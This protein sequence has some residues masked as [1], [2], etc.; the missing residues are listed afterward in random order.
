MPTF[1]RGWGA[2]EFDRS[3]PDLT[4][5]ALQAYALWQPFMRGR[6]ALW[7]GH[8]QRKA[9]NYLRR[10]QRGDGSWVPL[11]FGN[12]HIPGDVNPTYATARVVSCLAQCDSQGDGI[13]RGRSWLIAAQR[14]DGSWGGG[15][16]SP[17]SIEETG[18]AL[19]ALSHGTVDLSIL[20]RGQ[21]ALQRLTQNGQQF[22]PAPI[23]FYFAKLWYFERLYP[24]IFATAGMSR[25]VTRSAAVGLSDRDLVSAEAS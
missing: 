22:Q 24:L 13:R 5:H 18:L 10:S 25:C 19:E 21:L 20:V 11:W 17:G 4:A 15:G 6:L 8:S 7:I 3:A 12:Q 9:L 14:A 16:N 2:L 23:G 1:C